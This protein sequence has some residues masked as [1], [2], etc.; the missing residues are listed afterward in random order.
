MPPSK[1]GHPSALEKAVSEN[2]L[3]GR[4]EKSVGSF[5]TK[6][7]ETMGSRDLAASGAA[8]QTTGQA[9]A[10]A[11]KIQDTIDKVAGQLSGTVAK[12]GEKTRSAYELTAE[13]AQRVAERVRPVATERPYAVAGAAL[14]AG[15]VIGML[16]NS[17]GPKVIYVKPRD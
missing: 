16:L 2:E 10:M 3:A 9:R 14:V 12:A 7:G 13:R 1:G 5:E 11:G 4:V 8:R 6:L 17:R 15:M